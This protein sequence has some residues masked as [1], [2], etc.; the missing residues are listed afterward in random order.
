ML[1]FHVAAS[2]VEGFRA[3]AAETHVYDRVL[4]EAQRESRIR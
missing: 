4:D 2:P 1:E 3:G